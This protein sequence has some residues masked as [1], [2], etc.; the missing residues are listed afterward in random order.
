LTSAGLTLSI[1]RVQLVDVL[2]R[3]TTLP[4]PLPAPPD[5]IEA[6]LLG[7]GARAPGW[8]RLR[9]EPATRDAAA[10]ILLYPDAR[11]EAHLVLT[12]RPTGTHR[13]AGQISFPGGKRD[14]GDEFPIGTALREAREEVGLDTDRDPV[15]LLGTLDVVDVRVSGFLLVPVIAVAAREPAMTPDPHEVA[16]ILRVPVRHFLPDAPIEVMEDER[17]GW[18]L[19]Y[20]AYPVGEH[21]IWGATG[22]I[23]GQLGAVLWRD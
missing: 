9:D 10:L 18:R 2:A 7:R 12:E 8:V 20:G 16:A 15:T 22:R 3:L 5:A 21:R 17:D 4:H 19:R 1:G 6:H 13:H 14:P 23:L 11:G